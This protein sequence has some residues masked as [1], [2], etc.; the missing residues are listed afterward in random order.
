MS[1]TFKIVQLA[2]PGIDSFA[3]YSVASVYDYAIKHGHQHRVQRSVLIADM[4]INWSKIAM[5][6]HALKED[7]TDFVVLLDADIIVAD[8]ARSLEDFVAMG[9]GIHI[10]MPEDTPLFG[11]HRPNAGFIIVRN[12]PQGREIIDSWM[13]AARNEGKHLADTHPR[14]QLVYWNFVMPRYKA[15]QYLIPRSFAAKYYSIFE[16]FGKK[17]RFLW[18][19]TQTKGQGR[20]KV[21]KK[22]YMASQPNASGLETVATALKTSEGWVKLT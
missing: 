15:V 18:H 5:L 7:D 6:Q 4:H 14:N 22:L 2:T 3:L 19:V 13:S 9:S 11:G 1:N 10:W 21:M 20:E 16:Y 12:G 8:M 17:N